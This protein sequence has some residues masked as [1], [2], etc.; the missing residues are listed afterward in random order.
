[1]KDYEE[2]TNDDNSTYHYRK[3]S[4]EKMEFLGDSILGYIVCKYIYQ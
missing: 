3:E 2:Y 4:Y 1:M